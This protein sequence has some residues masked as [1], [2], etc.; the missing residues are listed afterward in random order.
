MPGLHI[1]TH[2]LVAHK[3]THLRDESTKQ[4]EFRRLLK[5]VTYNLGFEA[6]T[7]LPVTEHKVTTP[8]GSVFTGSKCSSDI[9]II[10]ILRAGLGMADGMLDLLPNAAV[11]HIGMYRVKGSLMPVQYYNRLPSGQPCDIAYVVDPCIATSN[12]ISAVVGIV[13][14]WGA[15]RVVVI[16]SVGSQSGVDALLEKHPDIDVYIGQVDAE[17]SDEGTILPGLGDAGDRQFCTDDVHE[18]KGK[19]ARGH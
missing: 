14:S 4:A 8:T 1:S 6:T 12:T 9:A 15:K 7:T 16:S 17:L 19:R 18:T 13:K 11:H 3:M 5:E 2:P 10:P